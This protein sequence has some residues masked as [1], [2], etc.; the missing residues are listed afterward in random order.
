MEPYEF[1]PPAHNSTFSE[2]NKEQVIHYMNAIFLLSTIIL[3]FITGRCT[4]TPRPEAP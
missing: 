3:W 2:M 1:M 4:P